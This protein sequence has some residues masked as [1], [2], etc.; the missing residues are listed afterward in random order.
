MHERNYLFPI[1]IISRPKGLRG[2]L[3]VSLTSTHH[4]IYDIGDVVW[5][6]NNPNHLHQWKIEY[7]KIN[8]RKGYLK[9]KDVNNVAEAEYFRNIGVYFPIVDGKEFEYLKTKGF[10][11]VDIKTGENLGKIVDFLLNTPQIQ[12]VVEKD[13]K[14]YFIPCVNE[15]VV[16]INFK[17]QI[18]LVNKFEGL[19]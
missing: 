2:E 6:G 10:N 12:L 11:V 15:I 18:V 9:L 4:Y 7:F 19:M 3:I 1:G 17:K 14:E 8:G 5:L 16:R 13:K